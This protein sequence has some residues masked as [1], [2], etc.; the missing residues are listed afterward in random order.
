[1]RD[2]LCPVNRRWPLAALL[3]ALARDYP[4]R[5]NG[6]AS[7]HFVLTEYVM[8][9]G[10]NDTLDDARRSAPGCHESSMTWN[11]ASTMTD[12]KFCTSWPPA[13]RRTA[14]VPVSECKLLG[15]QVSGAAATHRLQ[16]Q[17][18][19]VQYARGHRLQAFDARGSAGVPVHCHSGAPADTLLLTGAADVDMFM[20][21]PTAVAM[22]LL[23]GWPGVHSP[24]QP[25]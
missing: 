2:W 12:V 14:A 19:R 21:L 15:L 10:V 24:R 4:R 9:S 7:R 11:P 8:L 25:R 16:G 1:V 17:P 23:V 18:D 5:P 6:A 22:C 20:Q 3:G 13:A